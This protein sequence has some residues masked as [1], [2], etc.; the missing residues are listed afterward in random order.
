MAPQGHW[1]RGCKVREPA[2]SVAVKVCRF[3]QSQD[4]LCPPA[5]VG[6]QGGLCGGFVPGRQGRK[7]VGG[8]MA[9]GLE[10]DWTLTKTG[11]SVL[12]TAADGASLPP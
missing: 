2:R 11:F 6:A 5:N 4:P 7:K 3:A 9:C 8:A 1:G 12:G 10:G